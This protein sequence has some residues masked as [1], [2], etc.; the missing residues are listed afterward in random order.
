MQRPI[1]LLAV[2]AALAVGLGLVLWM[3]REP[4]VA[5]IPEGPERPHVEPTHATTAPARMGDPEPAPGERAPQRGSAIDRSHVRFDN[6]LV[7]LVVD[8]AQQPLAGVTLT[9]GNPRLEDYLVT[10]ALL[11]PAVEEHARTGPD[12]KF[13]FSNLEPRSAYALVVQHP[14]FARLELVTVPVGAS[15]TFTE[16]TIVLGHG[17]QLSGVVR[18]EAGKPIANARLLLDDARFQAAL[19]PSVEM[20]SVTSDA[21]GAYAF[22]NVAPGRRILNVSAD[23]F[24]TA[25]VK[26]LAFE[27]QSE[28][29]TRDV[30]LRV[31]ESICG[32]VV[33]PNGEPISGAT[34]TAI[35][36][37]SA[38]HSVRAQATSD[39]QGEFC[40]GALLP[41]KY[42]LTA[43]VRGWRF[44]QSKQVETN[45]DKVTLVGV[46]EAEIRGQVLDHATARPLANFGVRLRSAYPG[47]DASQVV[48]GTEQ[49][50]TNANGEFV[51]VGVQQSGDATYVVEAWAAG[52]APGRS[53]EFAVE[54]DHDVSGID[55]RLGH[56]GKL[57]GRILDAQGAPVAGALVAPRDNE[58]TP[59]NPFASPFSDAQPIAPPAAEIRTDEHGAFVLDNLTPQLYQVSVRALGYAG[60]MRRDVVVTL[61]QET[62]LGDVRLLRGGRVSGTLL[63]DGKP[64]AGGWIELA[65]VDAE[66]PFVHRV[67]TGPLGTFDIENVLPGSYRLIGSAPAGGTANPLEDL[68]SA[69]SVEQQITIA[70][71][72]TKSKI[73]VTVRP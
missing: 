2:V 30:V 61:D 42:N 36:F 70:D 57:K 53:A 73:D 40:V 24:G 27:A 51:I 47:N 39:A 37:N 22:A 1:A 14:S 29:Q 13:D 52:Y 25:T 43:R 26:D 12:G 34:L 3:L 19:E 9:L 46:R 18:D 68:M 59:N 56:G 6:H 20:L 58:W 62:D 10:D 23:G 38:K 50:V 8:G 65:S 35:G 69:R 54:T 31:A 33:G 17:A 28:P 72:E 45:K 55:V 60:S 41:G 66:D 21:S 15:G 63:D 11:Q 32:R 16:P 7:G 71:G 4:A 64:L 44:E 49:A 5:P 67:K 48:A